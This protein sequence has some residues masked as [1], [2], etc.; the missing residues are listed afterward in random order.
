[1]ANIMLECLA[2]GNHTMLDVLPAQLSDIGAAGETWMPCAIC[3]RDTNWKAADIGR[4]TGEDR[5]RQSVEATPHS[6]APPIE[7]DRRSADRRQAL[8]RHKDR[9]PMQV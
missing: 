7:H 2:C 1:M 6:A 5:R 3:K 9:I 8:L 4:R